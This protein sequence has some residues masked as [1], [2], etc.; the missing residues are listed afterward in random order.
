MSAPLPSSQSVERV[1]ETAT[2]PGTPKVWK[3]GTL[4]YTGSGI[5]ALL[6]LLVWGD[7]ALA[8]RD[9]SVVEMAK[10]Y[11]NSLDVPSWLFGL[12]ITS[13]PGAVALFLGPIISMKSDRHR[14]KW[15]RRIPFLL[16][17]T[18]IAA[19][20]MIGIALTPIITKALQGFSQPD[21]LIGAPLHALLG[22]TSWGPGLLASLENP[23]FMSVLCFAGFWACFEF[24]IIAGL[25]V[26]GGLINDVV[27]QAMLGRVYALF[28]AI[29]LIDGMIFSYYIFGKVPEHFTLIMLI[30]G[31]FYGVAFTWVC[32]KVK[33]GSYPPPPPVDPAKKSWTKGFWAGA[34]TYY[35][36]CFSHPYYLRVFLMIMAATLSFMPINT[37]A[38]PYA[39][40]LAVSMDTFGKYLALT[41][42]ISMGLALP[43]GWLVDKVHP[44]RVMI[45]AMVGYLLVTLWGT[46]YANDASSFITA[47]VLHGV[48]SGCYFTSAASIGQRLY[49]KD[50]FSQFASAALLFAAP[51]QMALAPI[52]GTIIDSTGKVYRYAFTAGMILACVALL[53]A[54]SVYGRFKQLGGP[55]NYVAP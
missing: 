8:L 20:G 1:A 9:R 54:W 21:S 49:P 23:M 2:P 39:K 38:Q 37:F 33:E 28:R 47:W 22:G 5:T 32:F 19:F 46:L 29:S 14:G 30:I 10:W 24:S 3:V 43:L 40:S 53:S 51:L 27:P 4:T 41:F 12:L 25:S 35:R 15:G 7:F 36:E 26:F 16:V 34:T 45:G 13:F 48:L 11:L 55:K 6:L 31:V 52:V 50:R 42:M 18:P 44:L 17:T